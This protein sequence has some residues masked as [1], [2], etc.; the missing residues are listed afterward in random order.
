[1]G[2]VAVY[3]LNDEFKSVLRECKNGMVTGFSYVLAKTVL[4]LPIFF[5]FAIFA[6]G[7]PAFVIQDNGPKGFGAQIII[8]AAIM[9]VFESVAE[10]LSVW[11]EDPILGMLQFMNFWFGAFLFGG[12]LIPPE[13]MY[14]PFRLFYYIM[15]Y[16]AYARSTAYQI[17]SHT[18]FE[19]CDPATNQF[20]AICIPETDGV[21][22]LDAL[23]KV[24]PLLSKND[25]FIVDL[26]AALAIGVFY[27][28][29]YIGGALYKTTRVAKI[30]DN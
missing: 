24:F 18:T 10:A 28:V 29:L 6:L 13:D 9:F 8:F 14:W 21:K 30:H 2:V 7:I 11:F 4:V 12:F 16:G 20:S 17:F 23:S 1:M 22:V 15:P 3:A 26:V 27:K 5:I 19:A 25:N